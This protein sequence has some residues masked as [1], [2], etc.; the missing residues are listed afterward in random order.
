M[1]KETIFLRK[2]NYCQKQLWEIEHVEKTI[3]ADF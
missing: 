1:D 2:V 3:W